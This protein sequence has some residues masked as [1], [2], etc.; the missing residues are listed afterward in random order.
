MSETPNR[1]DIH[2]E[3][4]SVKSLAAQ[5]Y[6][7]RRPVF[8]RS[9]KLRRPR[10]LL[11][12]TGQCPNCM[13]RVDGIPNV[14]VCLCREMDSPKVEVQNTSP[15]LDRTNLLT[16]LHRFLKV[17][18][19]YRVLYSSRWQRQLF[20]SSMKRAAGLGE[21]VSDARPNKPRLEKLEAELLIIGGGS[22]GLSAALEASATAKS[23]L[24]VDMLPQL[25]GE[26]FARWRGSL[27]DEVRGRMDALNGMR[28][29]ARSAPNIRILLETTIA[30][31]Y[32]HEDLF[33]GLSDS[34]T[35]EIKSKNVVVASGAHEVL[36]QFT[37]NDS[38][39]VMLSLS[40]QMLLN[41][42]TELG[43]SATVIDLDG[44][45][46]LVAADLKRRGMRV[47]AV[48][49][50]REFGDD[51]KEL[52]VKYDLRA[53]P[54]SFVS[55]ASGR[56]LRL[57]CANHSELIRT[58]V[59]V[60]C[61]RRQPNY[62]IASMLGC[63]LYFLRDG[64]RTLSVTSLSENRPMNV[65][66]A[67]SLGGEALTFE[68]CVDHGRATGAELRSGRFS[69]HEMTV[70]LDPDEYLSR[71]MSNTPSESYV[72]LCEDVTLSEV[73]EA[74]GNG[75][76]NV[77]TLKRF[78]GTLT[79]P[80]QGKQCALTV[81]SILASTGLKGPEASPFTTTRPPVTPVPF[82]SLAVD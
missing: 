12:S 47:E 13:M 14:P 23:I 46:M 9:S 15:L 53:A 57:Q 50:P 65:A 61:G 25:G 77:E 58:E 35:Y 71:G 62:E 2:D 49:S 51:A 56:G 82:S 68:E 29:L 27:L 63:D 20:Y 34:A 41:S 75:Y 72:C 4:L 59:I 24:L 78:T 26:F 69:N 3:T 44:D 73:L 39:R 67:G 10:G 17:G 52:A 76:D 80:C 30:G 74:I 43:R 6:D 8:S 19:Q 81:A 45:G 32:R 42:G 36:P 54:N 21:A 33:V 60:V 16:R 40:S 1:G 66:V 38:P 48:S 22:A 7:P 37:N 5:L 11:C 64:K 70:R 18:F 28:K 79:G 31:Y 55:E